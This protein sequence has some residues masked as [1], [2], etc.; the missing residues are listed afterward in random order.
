[1]AGLSVVETKAGAGEDVGTQAERMMR[2]PTGE[3]TEQVE[4]SVTEGDEAADEA[5]RGEKM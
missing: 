3:A 1:M 5:Y 4:K 2:D